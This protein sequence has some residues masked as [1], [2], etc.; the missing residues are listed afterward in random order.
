[1]PHNGDF[2]LVPPGRQIRHR[3][4][5]DNRNSRISLPHEA[6][7]GLY[8]GI[9][10]LLPVPAIKNAK[11]HTDNRNLFRR[12]E[13]WLVH[14]KI[15]E[16]WLAAAQGAAPDKQASKVSYPDFAANCLTSRS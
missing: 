13:Q 8:T 14:F 15:D 1:L 3:Q 16:G 10:C 6:G 7:D 11:P 5:R 2:Q 12:G 9:F 4:W